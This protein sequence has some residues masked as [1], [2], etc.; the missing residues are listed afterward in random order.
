MLFGPGKHMGWYAV[1]I[2]YIQMFCLS[3]THT[4]TL[5]HKREGRRQGLKAENEE[6]KRE[7]WENV[8]T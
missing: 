3:F 2:H 4:H 8:V 5:S 7:K 6:K 1:K